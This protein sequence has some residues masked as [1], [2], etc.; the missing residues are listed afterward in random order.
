MHGHANMP[1]LIVS[2][3]CIV[4]FFLLKTLIYTFKTVSLFN[5]FHKILKLFGSNCSELYQPPQAGKPSI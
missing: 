4:V 2:L 1:N 5:T 3:K